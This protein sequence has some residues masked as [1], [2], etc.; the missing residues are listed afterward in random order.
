MVAHL[1]ARRQ[2]VEHARGQPGLG[3]ALGQDVRVDRGLGRGLGDDRAARGEAGGHLVAE[4]HERGVP[5]RDRGDDA[6]RLGHDAHL[7]AAGAGALVDEGI[8]V[9][10]AGIIIE[11]ARHLVRGLAGEADH[12]AD[13]AGPRL[14][15][16]GHARLEQCGHLAQ[17]RAALLRGHARPRAL[18]ERVARRLHRQID[19]GGG[20]LGILQQQL[21]VMRRHHVEHRAARGRGAP[22]AVDEQAGG[23]PRLDAMQGTIELFHF[24]VSLRRCAA[25]CAASCMVPCAVARAL[26]KAVADAFGPLI[27]RCNYIALAGHEF[28]GS[29]RVVKVNVTFVY[30][31]RDRCVKCSAAR[32]YIV[33]R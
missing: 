14:G 22:F 18:V 29:G 17:L 16:L 3:D 32:E 10:Q 4:Q 6:G 5:R 31:R 23:A 9:A 24:G 2:H 11:Q 15:Q 25:G 12:R 13:L 27:V 1:A 33:K 20:R 21:F 30:R 28:L 26:V 8:G 19:V 7:A